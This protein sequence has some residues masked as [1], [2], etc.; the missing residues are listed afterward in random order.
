MRNLDRTLSSASLLQI[1][2]VLFNGPQYYLKLYHTVITPV[3]TSYRDC[4][5]IMANLIERLDIENRGELVMNPWPPG[6]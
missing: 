2:G 6:M 4:V 3:T 1:H 5:S